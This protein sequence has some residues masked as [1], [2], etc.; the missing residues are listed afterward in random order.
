MLKQELI[1]SGGHRNPAA[2]PEISTS[3]TLANASLKNFHGLATFLTAKSTINELPFV[4]R[5]NLGNGLSFRNEGK[6]AFNHKW[7]NLNTQD[8]MP[9]WRWW[10]TDRNDQAGELMVRDLINAELTF[11]DAYFGGS[12]LK[13]TRKNRIL[14]C[15]TLQ[16]L[17]VSRRKRQKFRL[18]TR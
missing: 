7:Y 2:R 11:D 17:I 5:F 9:T 1:F 6:V 3:S 4:T 8:F 18:P 15:K 14:T 16:N 12:C 13:P 10:I